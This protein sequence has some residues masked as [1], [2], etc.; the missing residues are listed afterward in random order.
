M[1]NTRGKATALLLVAQAIILVLFGLFVDYDV[2]AGPRNNS[3]TTHTTLAHYYPI[4][5]D[6]HVMMLIGFGFLMTFLK[7]HGF[8]SV[9]FNFLLTCYVIEWSTLV[10]GWFGMIGSNEGRILIDIKSLLEADFA[11]ATVLISF[12]AVLGVASPVQLIMMATI[13]VV[14]YNV[15]IYVGIVRFQVTDVGGSMFIHA[16]GAYFGLAVA[17]VLYK[18]SQTLSKKE[19]SEYH[20]DIFAM[21]GTLFLW[22]Y[23]PS[24][25]AGPASGT[26]RH[27]AVINTVLSLS[28]CTVVTFALSAVTDKKNKLDMVHIQ[29][30]TL[31]G[32]VAM[33]ASADLIVQPFG[34][35]LIGSVAALVST[36][37]FKYLQPILQRNI[38]LHDTCG[39]HNLHGMPGILGVVAS[40]IAAAIATQETYK[41]SY[42]ELFKNT[43]RTSGQNGGYQIASLAVVLG[44]AI[45]GGTLTGFLLKL[46]VWDNLSAEELFEDEVFWDCVETVS[47]DE[48]EQNGSNDKQHEVV[49]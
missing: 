22:L 29:N 17:R 8:G 42:H 16:F 1:G 10:N 39:V 23:W 20:S 7:R 26:E 24:F 15:S 34:A 4:Y 38:K 49:A 32:G 46:P 45:I 2:A 41:D 6:V 43:T 44:I 11:V 13:E 31:A 25:N 48:A 5:Q 12:G 33:G 28:A 3:L 40:A 9:G 30:A 14:C 36:L 35:L 18:K 19:G 47:E 37:G 21:I 27:R